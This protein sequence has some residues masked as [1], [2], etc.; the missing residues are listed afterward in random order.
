MPR[1]KKIPLLKGE[2]KV[3]YKKGV[4]EIHQDLFCGECETKTIPA[5][6]QR[7]TVIAKHENLSRYEE[8]ARVCENVG[9]HKSG[10]KHFWPV[11]LVVIHDY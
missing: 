2:K 5:T 7:N 1:R 11:G 10:K 6:T 9:D 4:P 8:V 3:R